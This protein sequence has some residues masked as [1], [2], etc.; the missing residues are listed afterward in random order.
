M[1]VLM[2]VTGMAMGRAERLVVDMADAIPADVSIAYLKGPLHVRPVR[3]DVPLT[4]LGLESAR[5][6]LPASLRFRNAVH[7]FQPDIVHAHMFHAVL[8]TRLLRPVAHRARLVSSMHAY[9]EGWRFRALAFRSTGWLSDLSTHVSRETIR[10]CARQGATT[11]KRMVAIH[12]G[13]DVERFRPMPDARARIR[14]TY[15]VPYG[16]PL[17]LSAGR[18]DWSNDF[19]NLFHALTR[20]GPAFDYRLLVAG[21]GP[22]RL[23]LERM[24]QSWGLGPKVRFLGAVEEIPA[25]MS[26]ADVFVL[27]P[28]KEAFGLVLGEAMACGC[29]VVTTDGGGIRE[30]LGNDPLLLPSLVPLGDP[31]ALA[32]AIR[33]AC[34]LDPAHAAARR[35]AARRR[36]VAFSSERM[37]RAWLEVYDRLLRPA[38]AA[39][40]RPVLH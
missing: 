37:V 36:I 1:R 16:C 38:P 26:A 29:L 17:L 21:D 10:I 12:H 22:H 40:G 2:A 4:C 20:L 34:S 31:A 11:R 6:V 13:V 5:D 25:L 15:A 30:I 7:Q 8:L 23:R 35:L 28:V 14:E 19:P 33:A 3:T 39:P 32:R 9:H 27:S 24:V 18:L